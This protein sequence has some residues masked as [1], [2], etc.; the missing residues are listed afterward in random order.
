MFSSKKSIEKKHEKP[1]KKLK[2]N[3][4]KPGKDSIGFREKKKKKGQTKKRSGGWDE[5][6]AMAT[7]TKTKPQNCLSV[8]SPK[9]EIR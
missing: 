2:K 8:T 1:K 3:S 6:V 7:T 9:K 5:V 4:V